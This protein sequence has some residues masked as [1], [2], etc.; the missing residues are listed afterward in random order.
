MP[1]QHDILLKANR[2]NHRM[3]KVSWKENIVEK[4][5]VGAILL[6]SNTEVAEGF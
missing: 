5:T 4:A 2:A 3:G 1:G 6:E